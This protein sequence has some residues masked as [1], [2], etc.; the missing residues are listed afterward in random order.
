MSFDHWINSIVM[1]SMDQRDGLE[2]ATRGQSQNPL[3]FKARSGRITASNCGQVLRAVKNEAKKTLARQLVDSK[4][5]QVTQAM[6][7][8]IEHEQQAIVKYAEEFGVKNLQSSGLYVHYPTGALGCSPDSIAC[9]PK[10]GEKYLV[11]VKCPFRARGY[12][13][14]D[15]V[16]QDQ[17]NFY[18]AKVVKEDGSVGYAL[19]VD[20]R[21]GHDYYSQI[22]LSLYVTKLPYCHF[23]VWTP[24]FSQMIKVPRNLQ[25]EQENEMKLF[26]FW[27]NYMAPLVFQ[28]NKQPSVDTYMEQ[29][30][31]QDTEEP[32]QK[33]CRNSETGEVE[34]NAFQ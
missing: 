3:W 33:M 19:R 2:E 1:H 6:R 17:P 27:K 7:W 12:R 26:S 29:G 28:N 21:R 10:T 9:D 18:L 20:N 34:E 4:S 8:G 32:P 14:L 16:I 25:W 15:N 5:S 11:E 31:E 23:Y 30:E 13:S 24:L 22:M